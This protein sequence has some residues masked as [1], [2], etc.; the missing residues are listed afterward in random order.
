MSYSVK[1]RCGNCGDFSVAQI[2]KGQDKREWAKTAKC[3][4][5]E[6]EGRFTTYT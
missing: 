3:K 2:P 6:V 5:C 4:K 1:T